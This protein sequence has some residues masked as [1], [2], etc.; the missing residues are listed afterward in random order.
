M[1]TLDRQL[2][3]MSRRSFLITSAVGS[4]FVM[5]C[6]ANILN[7]HSV[8]AHEATP[9][10]GSAFDALDLP[11]LE[12][13]INAGGTLDMPAEFPAGTVKLRVSAREMG[14]WST[15]FLQPPEGIT[16]ED[17]Q[18]AVASPELPDFLHQSVVNGSLDIVPDPET[19]AMLVQ[20]LVFDLGAGDWYVIQI[21]EQGS[22]YSILT[23]TGEPA[24]ADVPSSVE[25]EMRHH[26]FVVAKEVK[27]GKQIWK[28][29]NVD[30]EL[31]HMIIFSYPG[32]LTDEQALQALMASEGMATPPSGVDPMQIAFVGASGL[33]SKDQ[34]SF[35]VFDLPPGNYFAVCFITDPGMDVPHVANGMI[36]VFNAVR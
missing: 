34:T 11:V 3:S 33:L 32:Q 25:I 15:L 19:N 20:E 29:T 8:A 36:Q 31:H 10:T 6:T 7:L 9:E 17:I 18:A 14:A 2:G 26:D 4:T 21:A 5:T 28:M 23:A 16:E 30:A 24:V 22:S 12:V 35:V 1:G 27:A 13:T